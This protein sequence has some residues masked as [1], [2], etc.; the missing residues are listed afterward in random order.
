MMFGKL[1]IIVDD[2][3]DV[4]N[5]SYTAWR[6]LN[7]VDWKRDVVIADRSIGRPRSCCQFPALRGSKMG[8]DA[9]RKTREE[10]MMREWPQELF[11]SEIQ[12]P[13]DARWKEYGF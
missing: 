6:V 11:M 13:V 8:I 5:I 10:G 2:D 7:N 3:V 1:L 12:A 4:Q 9:T